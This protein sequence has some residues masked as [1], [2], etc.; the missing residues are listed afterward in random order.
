[1]P[2]PNIIQNHVL[3]VAKQVLIDRFD[4]LKRTA[5]DIIKKMGEEFPLF[6]EESFDLFFTQIEN[7][8]PVLA[9]QFISDL[10]VA[11]SRAWEAF[12]VDEKQKPRFPDWLNEHDKVLIII[13]RNW[14]RVDITLKNIV[15]KEL[16]NEPK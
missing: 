10:I 14:T 13:K 11:A 15:V 8:Y 7:D 5:P 3:L 1:M 6:K 16:E 2:K 9:I 4:I 12:S